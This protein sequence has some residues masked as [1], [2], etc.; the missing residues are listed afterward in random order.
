MEP[1]LIVGLSN[2]NDFLPA[3]SWDR[4]LDVAQEADAAGV[5]SLSVVD[6][7]V[8]GGDLSDYPYGAFPGGVDAPW[9]EPLTTLAAIAGRTREVRLFTG[10]LIAPLRPPALLAKITATLDQLSLGRLDLGVGTGWLAKE[11]EAVGLDFRARGR[12]LDDALEVC[13]ALWRGGPVSHAS[14][15]LRFDDVHCSPPPLQPGGVPLWVGGDL[16]ARNVARIVRFASGWIPSPPTGRDDAAAG[17]AALAEA[18]RA[19]GRDPSG[20]RV[21]MTL[22]VVRDD[23]G[24]PDLARSLDALPA[25]VAAGATDVLVHYA[26][27]ARGAG[28]AARFFGELV[29]AFR[30]AAAA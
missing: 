29:P 20:F 13:R 12:L 17:A 23:A 11:Y 2:Y 25:L 24:H 22:P 19:A 18:L 6:H 21:R 14:D 10:V 30:A 26:A 1:R 28:D 27:F 9:L 8:L 5:D 4:L 15:H 3:G 7:V 16:H